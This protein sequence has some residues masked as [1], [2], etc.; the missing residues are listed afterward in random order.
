MFA[1]KLWLFFVVKYCV[2]VK[3]CVLAVLAVLALTGVTC[4]SCDPPFTSYVADPRNSS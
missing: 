1:A 3:Y 4:L 2:F